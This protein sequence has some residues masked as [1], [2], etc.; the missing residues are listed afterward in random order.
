MFLFLGFVGEGLSIACSFCGCSLL[1]WIGVFILVLS[2]GLDLWIGI[3][4][5]DFVMDYLVFSVYVD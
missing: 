5:A 2:V 3:I 1:P 4:K